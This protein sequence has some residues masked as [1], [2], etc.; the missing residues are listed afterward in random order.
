MFYRTWGNSNCI[1]R[2][3]KSMVI[4][5]I[6]FWK[7]SDIYWYSSRVKKI[8]NNN[9]SFN[10]LKIYYYYVK[11]RYNPKI[12]KSN[13]QLST[14]PKSSPKKAKMNYWYLKEVSTMAYFE[15]SFYPEIFVNSTFSAL[16]HVKKNLPDNQ[17]LWPKG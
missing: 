8:R 15:P 9:S 14:K 13:N 16:K 17:I 12:P 2:K 4:I 6:R 1:F 10:L 5:L 7:K 11:N 3:Y